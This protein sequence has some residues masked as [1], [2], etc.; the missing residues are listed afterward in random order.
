MHSAMAAAVETFLKGTYED[1][2]PLRIL[3]GQ[4]D[5]LEKIVCNLDDLYKPHVLCD[6]ERA[7]TEFDGCS[8][9]Q[10]LT[11]PAFQGINVNMLPIKYYDLA[12][13][14]PADLNGYAP[15]IKQCFVSHWKMD[16]NGVCKI[17]EYDVDKVVYLTIHESVVD[18]GK[19]QRRSGLHIERPTVMVPG[20]AKIYQR[21]SKERS[22]EITRN[23][24]ATREEYDY[25]SLAWGTGSWWNG[26]P[27]NGI[28]MASSVAESCALYPAL[29]EKPEEVADEHGGVKC[30]RR[31]LPAPTLTKAN[32]LYWL[33]DRTPHES[34]PMR[35]GGHR[36]FFRLVV[37]PIGVWYAKHNTWNPL[38]EPNA[39]ICHDDK[40]V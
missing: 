8:G 12:N 34:L 27:V 29:I 9:G 21:P 23:A 24:S 17:G 36:Q 33:T 5:V 11:F 31:V 20:K 35:E 14:L 7:F 19:T 15:M 38:C 37:G 2:N 1:D 32:T 16:E 10:P 25:M 22:A 6:P 26:I 13:T 4:K 40:F 28:Y 18:P 3:N 39:P 30:L